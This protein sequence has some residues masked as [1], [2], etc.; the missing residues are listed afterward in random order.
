MP[1]GN[2][3]NRKQNL[4]FMTVIMLKLCTLALLCLRMR[5][6]HFIRVLDNILLECVFKNIFGPYGT[7][8]IIALLVHEID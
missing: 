6:L 1:E 5:S 7:I 4:C 3:Y 8:T 2:S